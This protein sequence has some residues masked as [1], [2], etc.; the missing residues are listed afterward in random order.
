MPSLQAHPNGVTRIKRALAATDDP[1]GAAAKLAAA[2]DGTAREEGGF[3][4]VSTGAG[5]A[6][7]GFAPR[8]VIAQAA[9]CD[10][11][12]LP[13]EGGAAMVLGTTRPRPPGFA[14]GVAVIF[15]PA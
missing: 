9:Q 6:E 7:I 14:T 8:A 1:A 11:A 5:R 2:I 13:H 3:H 4:L 10:A 15:E 12:S